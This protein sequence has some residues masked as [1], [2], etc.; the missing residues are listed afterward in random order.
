MK[1]KVDKV[2]YKIKDITLAERCELNDLVIE[3]ADKPSFSMWVKVVQ[4]CT[5]LTDDQ[6]NDM[7]SSQIIQLGSKC[8]DSVNKKKDKR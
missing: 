1:V 6:I 7:E 8:I 4:I 5:D 3:R 2:E